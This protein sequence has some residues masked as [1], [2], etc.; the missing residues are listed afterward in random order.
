[1][2]DGEGA[3]TGGLAGMLLG[4][5]LGGVIVVAVFSGRFKASITSTPRAPM[6]NVMYADLLIGGFHS[7]A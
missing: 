6:P 1:M 4:L 2:E 7:H 5:G 3:C